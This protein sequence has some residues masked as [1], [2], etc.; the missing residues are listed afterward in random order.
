MTK[1]CQRCR[2]PFE[3]RNENIIECEC[4]QFRIPAEVYQYISNK[5]KRFSKELIKERQRSPK[6]S[7]VPE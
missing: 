2:E 3:C 7:A 4:I 5:Q 1:E 6:L